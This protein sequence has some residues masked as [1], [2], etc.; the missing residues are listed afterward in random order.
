MKKFIKS[1]MIALL[2][3][4]VCMSVCGCDLFG[5]GDDS[6]AGSQ[7]TQGVSYGTATVEYHY[8]Y[9]SLIET[10][11]EEKYSI[12]SGTTYELTDMYTPPVRPGYRFLGWTTEKGGAGD[13]IGDTYSIKG[14][15]FKGTIYQFYAKYEI[16][17]F[18]VVYHLN[19][20]VNHADNPTS[21]SGKQ[22][23]QKPTR[24]K[25][26]FDGWYREPDFQH[27]TDYAS[28]ADDKTTTVD[29]YAK[30]TR[31]YEI[32]CVSDNPK[33]TVVGDQSVHPRRTFTATD[34]EFTVNLQPEYFKGY[35]FL[36]WEI[37]DSGELLKEHKLIE[38]KPSK[39]TDDITYTAHYLEASNRLNTPGLRVMI[40]YGTPTYYAR[41]DVTQIIIEDK[42]GDKY[43]ETASSVIIYYSGENPPEVL[44]REGV[45]VNLYQEPDTVEAYFTKWG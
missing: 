14:A 8:D 33:V 26:R 41:E 34:M 17:P 30:W 24:E 43:Y 38:I 15:G 44:C 25:Y 42:Y 35:M 12:Q 7:G 19:G 2:S 16:I 37:D 4:S 36:G 23:L 1:M 22:K 28:M 32:T 6:Q 11:R 45:T 20:G 29:L 40:S 31:L 21:L 9:E 5:G 3:L 39:V 27:S 13:V 10:Y 18:E